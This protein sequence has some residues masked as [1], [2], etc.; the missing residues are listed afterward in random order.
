[1]TSKI[2]NNLIYLIL[3]CLTAVMLY[4]IAYFAVGNDYILASPIEVVKSAITL[5]ATPSF[6]TALGF[7]LLRVLIA[8]L[9]SFAAAVVIAVISY[10]NPAI[11][12]VLAV[13]VAILRSLPVLAILLV[14][15]TIPRRDFAPVTVCFL[16]LFPILYTAILTSLSSVSKEHKQMCKVYKVPLSK[17]VKSLY[18]PKILP[19]LISSTASGISFAVKLIVSAEILALVYGSIGS[20]IKEASIYPHTAEVLA[21]SFSVCIIGVIVEFIGKILSE[22]AEKKLL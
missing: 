2:K 5:Y 13:V 6:Y 12:G 7:T 20:L 1:M 9:I 10:I 8:F 4:V 11:K 18:L 19:S 16:S 21:L 14:I 3:G 22:K 17:Q 15:L